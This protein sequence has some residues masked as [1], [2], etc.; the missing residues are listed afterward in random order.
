MTGKIETSEDKEKKFFYLSFD[1]LNYCLALTFRINEILF[2]MTLSDYAGTDIK[3][4]F[5]F[6][7]SRTFSSF[8]R[9][10]SLIDYTNTKFDLIELAE[11]GI[12]NIASDP[13]KLIFLLFL[14][15]VNFN[16]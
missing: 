1:D 9:L 13:V 5:D 7:G 11:T 16:F 14:L 12:Y 10:G 4:F 3:D 2:S 6:Y 8:I 15:T